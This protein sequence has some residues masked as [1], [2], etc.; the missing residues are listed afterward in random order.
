MNLVLD[1][2]IAADYKSA[3]QRIRVLTEYWTQKEI[4][5]P[6]CEGSLLSVKPNTPVGDFICKNCSETYELKSKKGSFG[7]KIPD[8][9]YSTVVEKLQ[10][11]EFPNFFFL[12]YDVEISRVVNFFVIPRHFFTLSFI[13]KRKPLSQKARRAGWVG[14]NL[15]IGEVPHIGRI[16]YVRDEKIVSK[17][18]IRK[19][20]SSTAF[21][22]ENS[23]EL[24]GWALDVMNCIDKLGRKEFS[25]SDIYQYEKHLK[26]YHPH[27]K[28]IKE[29]IRQQLQYL[30]DKR[31]IDF[32]GN[33]NYRKLV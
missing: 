23:G 20:W 22:K 12:N 16:Y 19:L 18:N 24:R 3:S 7:Y 31:Y 13:E 4:F 26:K 5:C 9:A 17:S 25:L 1:K 30:R 8:G 32:L 6:A 27:N 28:H 29:K 14:C 10:K 15:L 33:G 2:K 11:D 21:L